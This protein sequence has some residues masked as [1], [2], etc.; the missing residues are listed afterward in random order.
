[1]I[2]PT[3]ADFERGN[4]STYARTLRDVREA[5]ER[6]GIEFLDSDNGGAGIRLR[7]RIWRLTP[8]DLKP[9][10]WLRSTHKKEV[11][12][13]A[14]GEDQ[15]RDLA[16]AAFDQAAGKDLGSPLPTRPWLQPALVKCETVID[17][18]RSHVGPPGIFE[19]QDETREDL[20]IQE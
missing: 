3:V 14:D 7:P 16:A 10:D 20:L 9:D 1:M 13:R 11:L 5:L 6:G 15:A 17:G 8:I 18:E 4:R 12:L 19:P 2:A